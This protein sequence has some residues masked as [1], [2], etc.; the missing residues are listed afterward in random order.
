MKCFEVIA[1]QDPSTASLGLKLKAFARAHGIDTGF[2][3]WEEIRDYGDGP[4]HLEDAIAT[5]NR[6]MPDHTRMVDWH[7]DF[8]DTLVYADITWFTCEANC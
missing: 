8:C 5:I 7:P 2:I 3:S 4:E 1:D 6:R